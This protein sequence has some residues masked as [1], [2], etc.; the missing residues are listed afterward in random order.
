MLYIFIA[1]FVVLVL[2]N[3][4]MIFV[5]RQMTALTGK[6]VEKD[7]VRLMAVYDTL[8]EQ[9]SAQLR[10]L[11]LQ[12][13]MY[14]EQMVIKDDKLDT[15][16]VDS[17]LANFIPEKGVR[18]QDTEFAQN[19]QKIKSVFSITPEQVVSQVMEI[20]KQVNREIE[21]K[22]LGLYQEILSKISFESLYE[23]ATLELEEQKAI[24]RE[25][26]EEEEVDVYDSWQKENQKSDIITFFSW[27]QIQVKSSSKDLIVRTGNEQAT[28]Y[29]F[30]SSICEGV[31][32][33]YGDTLYD[34]SI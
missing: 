6:Q 13:S 7:A 10:E 4:F 26:L 15:W 23:I 20:E 1:V 29:Q 32:V 17:S 11:N 14:E 3:I 12:K 5:L 22:Q 28:Q 30:D 24:L 2:M 18:Y 31:K 16:T 25:V 34:F 21:M 27:L 8:L 19:Y 33:V 9:K